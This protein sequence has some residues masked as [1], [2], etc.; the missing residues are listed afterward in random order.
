MKKETYV[1]RDLVGLLQGLIA[2]ENLKGAKFATIASKNRAL[3]SKE[4]KNIEVKAEPSEDFL[5][6][7]QEMQQYDMQKDVDKVKAKEAEEE[8]KVVIDARK[9]QLEEVEVLL[10][11]TSNLNLFKLAESHLPAD[12]TL[13]QLEGIN[14]IVK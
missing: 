10:D 9:I 4:L 5:K 11:G 2:V 13:K 8:N 7:A 3:I 12:I 1:K 14:L 6:L